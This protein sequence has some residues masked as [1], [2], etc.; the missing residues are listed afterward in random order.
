MILTNKVLSPQYLAWLTPLVPL[1]SGRARSAVWVSF[2]FVG[3][4]TWY[5]YPAHYADLVNL[6]QVPIALLFLR[7]ILL[8]LMVVWLWGAPRPSLP[9]A[10]APGSA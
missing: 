7:N 8:L 4:M 9:A 3:W 5:I 10:T 6:G 2:F 1:L